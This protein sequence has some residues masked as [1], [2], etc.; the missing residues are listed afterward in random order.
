ME[1]LWRRGLNEEMDGEV[2]GERQS[3][4]V[5]W[6]GDLDRNGRY[7]ADRE[8]DLLCGRYGNLSAAN[9]VWVALSFSLDLALNFGCGDGRE[10]I[11]IMM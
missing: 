6:S 3:S 4:L 10:K 5:S 11:V 7:D 8:S 9:G 1:E 2:N